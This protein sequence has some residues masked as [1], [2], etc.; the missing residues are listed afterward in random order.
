MR[1]AGSIWISF[2][3]TERDWGSTSRQFIPSSQSHLLIF[4]SLILFFFFYSNFPRTGWIINPKV[5]SFFSCCVINI[6]LSVKPS[7]LCRGW[8][9]FVDMSSLV[10]T[11]WHR[12]FCLDSINL[13]FL[14]YNGHE[15]KHDDPGLVPLGACYHVSGSDNNNGPG[16]DSGAS[17][18][19]CKQESTTTSSLLLAF[20]SG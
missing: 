3:I 11:R 17:R 16:R 1:T 4:T 2:Y 18:R 14:F 13:F 12:W 19:E 8:G 9:C 5:Y 20:S 6:N 15:T 7:N 10:L